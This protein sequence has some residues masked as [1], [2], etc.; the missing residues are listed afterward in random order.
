MFNHRHIFNVVWQNQSY[1]F[2]NMEEANNFID[3]LP[4]HLEFVA[5][6]LLFWQQNDS[7]EM[8]QIMAM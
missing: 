8:H 1:I 4:K 7:I 3:T 2:N 5:H 6:C